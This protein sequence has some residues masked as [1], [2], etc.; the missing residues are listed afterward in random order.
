MDRQT[1]TSG[2]K[3][4]YNPDPP[5]SFL[6][7]CRMLY[8]HEL[9]EKWGEYCHSCAYCLSISKTVVTAQYKGTEEEFCSEDCSAN[10]KMLFCHVSTGASASLGNS[11]RHFQIFL[12]HVEQMI[13][14]DSNQEINQ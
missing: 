12:H 14:L 8:H 11:N 7:G 10:Y 2:Y 3:I 6:P 9:K 4:M 13:N 5:L 1:D